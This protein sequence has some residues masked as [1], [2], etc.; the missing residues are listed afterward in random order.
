MRPFVLIDNTDIDLS[1]YHL[2]PSHK[3]DRSDSPPPDEPDEKH[4]RV[5]LAA[6]IQAFSAHQNQPKKVAISSVPPA[7][8]DYSKL[9]NHPFRQ[10]FR[11]AMQVEFAKLIE[12]E[13]FIPFST[14]EMYRSHDQ[15]CT[16][17]SKH[18]PRHQVIPMRWVFAYKSD[19]KG[20]ISKFK[21]RLCVRGDMQLP[22][23]QD[24]RTST[25]ASRT[26][27]TL[28]AIM[29]AFDLETYQM[30]VVNAFLN[31]K[32][33]Q[34]VYCHYPPGM[35]S[36]GRCLKLKRAVYGLRVAGKR[37]ENDIRSTLLSIN[38]QHCPD[39]PCLYHDGKMIIMVFVDDFLALYHRSDKQHAI[40]IKRKLRQ[41]FEMKDCGELT[42][43][44]GI[45]IARD[46]LN[47]KTW[48][49]RS[50]YIEKITAKFHLL[51]HRT[52][53]VPLP[54]QYSTTFTSD[55]K[56]D[57]KLINLYQQKC[58]S[59]L[60]PAIWTRPDVA[61]ANQILAQHLTKPTVKHMAAVDHLISY[62]YGTRDLAI[63]YDGNWRSAD[64]FMA[65]SDASFGDNHDRKSSEGFVFCL[66]GGPIEWS[67]RKQPTITT[68]KTEAELLAISQASKH[69][70]WTIRV[71]RFIDFDPSHDLVIQCDNKQSI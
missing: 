12:M 9:E 18:C 6:F 34:E 54:S 7:P 70:Y 15:N 22:A 53:R 63:C 59:T 16:G 45:R 67:S 64:A 37:W 28:I 52:P 1:A 3:R 17:S 56:L 69:L 27:Q 38:F 14:S 61:F 41:Q 4:Q 26:F 32:L 24:T 62:L 36:K 10:E 35:G 57:D 42:Q 11:D 65:A 33:D 49:D 13:A 43:F 20:F 30:D 5:N 8:S 44:I 71:F 68:S 58:G 40:D 31:S 2:K 39:D 19:D 48:L 25:L 55:D 66:F 21:A 46:R 50:A 51:N 60:F 23:D 47:R 29:T